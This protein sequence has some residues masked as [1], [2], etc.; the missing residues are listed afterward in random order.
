MG[1]YDVVQLVINTDPTTM[2]LMDDNGNTILASE[3]SV[4]D[5]SGQG[6]INYLSIRP[7]RWPLARPPICSWTLTW[8]TRS[9]S[10]R[11]PLGALPR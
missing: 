11:R 8:G 6:Q 4:I 1:T 2:T 10:S 7:S 5:P 3:I 9:P